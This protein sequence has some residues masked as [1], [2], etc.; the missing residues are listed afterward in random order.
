MGPSMVYPAGFAHFEKQRHRVLTEMA[1][2]L[3]W[4]AH[5]VVPG[6]RKAAA[7]LVANERTRLGLPRGLCSN[8][9][10]L[11]ENGVDL[12]V[13][14]ESVKP[15]ARGCVPTFVF[16]G[17]LIRWKCVDILLHALAR[18]AK[19]VPMRLVV[20]G[21]GPE[22]AGLQALQERLGLGAETVEFTGYLPQEKCAD[23]LSGATA[24]V[25][26]SVLECGGAVVLE[27]MAKGLPVIAVRWGGPADYLDESV[28][29]LVEPTNS[30]QMAADFAH[31]MVQLA[32][33]SGLCAQLGQ[34]AR[35][36]VEEKYDWDRKIDKVLGIYQSVAH[37]GAGHAN[38]NAPDECAARSE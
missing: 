21:D 15:A 32:T 20:V 14:G 33:D 3:A 30:A 22:R 24:L 31:A 16:L 28:G 34:A 19:E 27:A 37:V 35:R 11:V 8:V 5:R 26:P 12:Q 6:K 25:L 17:R 2:R 36:R 38:A 9:I 29:V 18:A 23:I 4:L 13:F 10:E 7:L 1:R